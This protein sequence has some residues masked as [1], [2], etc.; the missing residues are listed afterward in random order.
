MALE[1]YMSAAK[2]LKLKVKKFQ[3]LVPSFVE[4][5]GKNLVGHI[6]DI[7]SI[8]MSFLLIFVFVTF[9]NFNF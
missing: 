8:L 2:G 1:F 9:L 4:V 3:G 6:I 7:M 5:T